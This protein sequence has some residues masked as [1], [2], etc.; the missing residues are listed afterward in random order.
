MLLPKSY[1]HVI[2]VV[3]YLGKGETEGRDPSAITKR[4]GHAEKSLFFYENLQGRGEFSKQ[5]DA[6]HDNL[7][8]RPDWTPNQIGDKNSW[9]DGKPYGT[10]VQVHG[11]YRCTSFDGSVSAGPIVYRFMLGKDR[12]TY[13]DAARNAPS[14]G[15]GQLNG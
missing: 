11:H 2:N 3:P 1:Y 14:E 4:H 10:Y 5:Q 9:K 15:T 8:D 13:F 6:N 7:I 12:D